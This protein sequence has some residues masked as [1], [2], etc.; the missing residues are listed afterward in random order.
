VQK[1]TGRTFDAEHSQRQRKTRT[2]Q[3]VRG[4]G[5]RLKKLGKLGFQNMASHT[6]DRTVCVSVKC[7]VETSEQSPAAGEW[8]KL[9]IGE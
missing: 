1:T 4:A 8:A 9:V 3:K 5:K 6:A 2:L 7:N